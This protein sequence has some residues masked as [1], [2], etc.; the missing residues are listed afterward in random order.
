MP[1]TM[2][3]TRMQQE[4]RSGRRGMQPERPLPGRTQGA[5]CR[6]CSTDAPGRST[7]A[8]ASVRT[9]VLRRQDADE[10]MSHA[11]LQAMLATAGAWQGEGTA[12]IARGT[13]ACAGREHIWCVYREPR[14]GRMLAAVLV[15][16]KPGTGQESADS[17]QTSQPSKTRQNSQIS[18]G[19]GR[20]LPGAEM[21][22][23]SEGPLCYDIP[24]RL[25][26]LLTPPSS[27]PE[28]ALEEEPEGAIWYRRVEMALHE[29]TVREA[30]RR[31]QARARLF[32]LL[33]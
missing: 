16:P 20:S 1:H 32:R 10:G 31:A 7:A 11:L 6:T 26:E 28:R 13:Q 19:A 5:L 23:Q 12:M 14:W 18:Q 29:R 9:S 8:A 22:C 2:P 25:F 30:R 15:L 33:A 21:L 17:S 24:E 4:R 3:H 27:W